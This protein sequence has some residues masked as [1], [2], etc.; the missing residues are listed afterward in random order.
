MAFAVKA[1]FACNV[2]VGTVAELR[3]VH[4]RHHEREPVATDHNAKVVI[5]GTPALGGKMKLEGPE[6]GYEG[7]MVK[8]TDKETHI[9]DWQREYGP[10]GPLHHPALG[11]GARGGAAAAATALLTFWAF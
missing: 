7:A 3:T 4:H 1:L 9:G 6:Q 8:H 11:A 5:P 10:M 2:L